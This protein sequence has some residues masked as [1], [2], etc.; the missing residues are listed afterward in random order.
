MSDHCW[1]LYAK[2]NMWKNE[3]D[4]HYDISKFHNDLFW[5]SNPTDP[6]WPDI[7]G[8]GLVTGEADVGGN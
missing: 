3:K 1:C 7:A 2:E 8:Q 4:S 6:N 5:H